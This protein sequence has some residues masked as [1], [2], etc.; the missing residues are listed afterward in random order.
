MCS[1]RRVARATAVLVFLLCSSVGHPDA[2]ASPRSDAGPDVSGMVAVPVIL[3]GSRSYD[4]RGQLIT[5][6]WT[7]AQSPIGSVA[8]LDAS[9]P[10]PVFAPDLPGTYRFQLVV[11][12]EDGERS[13]FSSMTLDAFAKS[14]APNARAGNDR[15]VPIGAPV[16]L[17]AGMSSDPLLTPLTFRWSLVSTPRGSRISDADIVA[18]DSAT[19]SFT[20]DAVG[21]YVL[22]LE[23]SN[24]ERVSEDRVTVTAT[25]GNLRPIADAGNHQIVDHGGPIALTGAGSFDPDGRPSRLGFAW[26]LVAR[27]PGSTLESSSIR[28]ANAATASVTP[29]A[30][31]AYVFRLTVTDGEASDGEN[32]LVRYAK[33]QA[34]EATAQGVAGAT[35]MPIEN[36]HRKAFEH[37][38]LADFALVVSPAALR[39]APGAEGVVTV[40]LPSRGSTASV[41]KLTV[42]GLPAG[43][44]ATFAT[45]ILAFGD[46]TTLTLRAS[47][48]VPGDRYP[49]LVTATRASNRFAVTRSASVHL[50]VA[51]AVLGSPQQP[52]CG[53]ANLSGLTSRIYVAPGGSDGPACGRSTTSPCASIQQ[54][55]DNCP[56]AG[57]GVLVRHGQYKTTTTIALRDGVSVYGSCHFSGVPTADPAAANYRTLIVADPPPGAPAI[58]GESI[59]TPTVVSGLAVWSRV[60]QPLS[61]PSIVMAVSNSNGMTLARSSLMA[62]AAIAGG[63]P[64]PTP[65]GGAGGV[66]SSPSQL[67]TGGAGGAACALH[68][69]GGPGN[70][71]QGADN[72]EFPA[73]CGPLTCTCI[74]SNPAN[75]VGRPGA[76]NGIAGGTGGGRGDPGCG[77]TRVD[78]VPDGGTGNP[79]ASGAC[80]IYPG[81]AGDA[82][83]TFQGARWIPGSGGQ[84][85][86]GSAGSGGGGGGSG[87]MSAYAWYS[88]STLYPG[89]PGGGGGGGGCGGPG[90]LGGVQG[91]ASIALVLVNSTVSGVP[92]QNSFVPG[93]G[94]AGGWGY[95]GG[96]GGQ[97]GSGAPGLVG[98]STVV[99]KATVCT[100]NAPGSGGQ[101]GQ[102]GPGGA[103][104]G[105]AAGS[106]GPSIGIALVGGSPAPGTTV[107][108][109]AG[110][111]GAPGSI[112]KGGRNATQPIDP[113][114]CTGVDGS[115]GVQGASTAILDFNQR[116][117]ARLLLPGQRL[118]PLQSLY[119][120]SGATVLVMQDDGNLCLKLSGTPI[121]CSGTNG[122]ENQYVVMQSD[123]NLVQYDSQGGV[124]YSSGTVGHPG[125]YL[126]VQDNGTLVI[127]DG[128]TALWTRP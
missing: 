9:D 62:G 71:G 121:W 88:E 114:P 84:G 47:A 37:G 23:A 27:P 125:S 81:S 113:N 22:R 36:G 70:G 78:S 128:L 64:T 79:G 49:L 82:V 98:H 8:T 53:A 92:D 126:A 12:S 58:S 40:K 35:A 101:G 85:G 65:A 20:P 66:G 67:N 91:G 115:N 109:Y 24:G 33:D 61:A 110:L 51:T 95:D 13:R 34:I 46:S 112:G 11:T 60:G 102:G 26:R 17:D 93:P 94:G 25:A 127:Y 72:Q 19:P 118:Q 32:V 90:G 69:T 48:N 96:L 119:S 120:P 38:R 39:I 31:G 87:G 30:E 97:G 18:R 86:G 45:P 77:C 52:T 122:I 104:S 43:V 5:F 107:G 76:A 74:N 100:A 103:G 108:V 105:G 56:A 28:D 1:A 63:F 80:G 117:P 57:C 10:A 4:P 7:L 73:D 89:L 124:R 59:N 54:G 111:P 21:A 123:G 75:S 99:H 55:I 16:D 68:P 106:G 3:D 41:A 42:S 2:Q 15:H 50:R 6:R 44:T 83:G 14:A 29:D 116:S